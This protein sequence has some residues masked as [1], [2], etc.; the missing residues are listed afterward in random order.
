MKRIA[1]L[2]ITLALSESIAAPFIYPSEWFDRSGVAPKAGGT[3]RDSQDQDYKTFNPFRTKEISSIIYHIG[4]GATLFKLNPKTGKYIPCMASEMPKISNNGKRF[5][6][7]IRK[8]MKFSNGRPITA[9]DWVMTYTLHADKDVGSSKLRLIRM[10][11]DVLKASKVDKYTI[12]FDFPHPSA[13]AYKKMSLFPW[14]EHVFGPVY[15]QKGAKGIMAMW[16]INTPPNQI[17]SPGAWAIKDYRKGEKALFE[18]NRFF[19]VW[20]KDEEG[21]SLP[22]LSFLNRRILG[23]ENSI[24]TFLAGSLDVHYPRHAGDIIAIK[25]AVK[26]KNLDGNLMA[27]LSPKVRVYFLTF[28]WNKKDFPYKENLFRDPKFR[29]A[30]SHLSNRKAMV[31]LALGDTATPI[32]SS[33]SPVFK[34]YQ[35]KSTK[36]YEYNPQ[37]A[38]KLL[39]ELGYSKKDSGG[40][41]INKDGKRIEFNLAINTE[42]SIDNTIA[43]ILARDMQKAGIKV[44]VNN[45]SFK[46]VVGLLSSQ[47]ENR[48]W[49]A[50]MMSYGGVT[51]AFPYLAQNMMCGSVVHA[52][53]R[54]GE[55]KCL[56]HHEQKI[57][58]LFKK[59]EQTLN[60]NKRREIGR[61]ISRLDSDQQAM[62]YLLS[63]NY[64]VAHHNRIG[65]WYKKEYINSINGA[66]PSNYIANYFKKR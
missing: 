15:R 41:L 2:I 9:D 57:A 51:S 63:A 65:G 1:A 33:V 24:A 60:D 34:N 13:D 38:R 11:N 31:K 4:A 8:N 19:G 66:G 20:N 55:G 49:D 5:T 23:G 6:V 22:Y 50:V 64:H 44:N 61:E 45:L 36:K 10:G 53:N 16:D 32:Y 58:N 27:N 48:A 42:K 3:I 56:T 39:A 47:G 7:K 28:N 14:P 43:Q 35:F 52:F 30:M 59:G 62:I 17:V 18:K 21:R 26:D 46:S 29:K 12:Q 54:L 37:K 40:Y 25:K